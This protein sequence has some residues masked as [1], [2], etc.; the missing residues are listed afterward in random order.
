[1]KQFNY[2]INTIEELE[3]QL[4][5]IVITSESYRSLLVQVYSAEN[6]EDWFLRLS[7]VV[8]N[9]FSY[10]QIVGATSVGEICEGRIN[11]K[12][13]VLLL[14]FF[15]DV[16]L[17]IY[18]YG[19]KFG[20]EKQVAHQ[21]INQIKPVREL[22]KGLMILS[23][24][25]TNDS[26]ELLNTITN[27][28]PK[29]P[30]FGGGAGDYENK[31]KTLVYENNNCYSAGAVFVTFIGH[32]LH[33]S[34]INSLGW[35][36]LSK[37][38]TITDAGV[39][40]V[41]TIDNKPAF[42]V[43]KKYLGIEADSN[44]FQNSLEFPFLLS[45]NNKTVARTPFFV[46]K[47]NGAIQLVGDVKTGEKFRIGYG[48]PKLITDESAQLREKMLEF[49]P[50]A[51]FLYTCICR[52]FILQQE[53]DS[54]TQPFNRIA[55][56][57]GFYTFGEFYSDQN[58]NSLLNSTMVCV[59]FREGPIKKKNRSTTTPLFT[60]E[61]SDPYINQHNRILARLLYFINVL[62]SEIEEQNKELKELNNMKNEFLGI[63]AHDLRNPIALIMGFSDLLYEELEGEHKEF[64]QVIIKKSTGMLSLLEELLD[65]TKIESGKLEIKKN[66][67]DYKWFIKENIEKNS[68]LAKKKNILLNTDYDDVVKEVNMDGSKIDQVLDNLIGNAV[69]YSHPNS[70]ITVK[71]FQ[72]DKWVCTE[73]IDHGQGIPEGETSILFNPFKTTSV[74]PTAGEHSHGLGLA[75]VK[76]IIDAHRGEVGVRSEWGVGSTFYYKIPL[77]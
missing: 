52:R 53:V 40:S 34:L 65:V 57:G 16:E 39:V 10:A 75:I 31:R 30:I 43:Y 19:C 5:T 23:T 12:S 8:K 1:M 15:E 77:L 20:D 55:P 21:I 18:S 17:N 54:E 33:I 41:E 44:F 74:K 51:I 3:N 29:F 64:A 58:Y 69:K 71:V 28:F 62:M 14:S 59:G 60:Q 35:I 42:E 50:D 37:E 49:Q 76:K 36:P 73:I 45:R 6:E 46:N 56:T 24:P 22:I 70:I 48:N 61:E 66:V 32:N 68:Y 11:T 25:I 9:R 72:K 7:R 4:S 47:E 27:T 26:G 38:M 2:V 67:I 13:T 63:A